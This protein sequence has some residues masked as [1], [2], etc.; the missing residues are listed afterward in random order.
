MFTFAICPDAGCNIGLLE[1]ETDVRQ[2]RSCAV[3]IHV[4]RWT[5]PEVCDLNPTEPAGRR[6]TVPFS[7]GVS[8][9][10]VASCYY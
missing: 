9:N 8:S 3:S 10:L 1:G 4:N 7:K 2:E 6:A 5:A